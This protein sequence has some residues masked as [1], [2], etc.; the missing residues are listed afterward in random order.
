MIRRALVWWCVLAGLQVGAPGCFAHPSPQNS[1]EEGGLAAGNQPRIPELRVQGLDFTQQ[2]VV[3]LEGPK[4]QERHL[5][6]H[7]KIGPWTLM[8]VL[9]EPDSDAAVFENLEQGKGSIVYV[10]KQGVILSLAKSLEPTSVAPSSL[11]RGKT[12][13]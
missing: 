4:Q 2:S 11:Y 5:A 3:M 13:D 12:M 9:H 1:S 10:G 6:L 8:A 7:E